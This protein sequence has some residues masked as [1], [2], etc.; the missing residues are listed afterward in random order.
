[1]SLDE[2]GWGW[3]GVQLVTILVYI[4]MFAPILV[5]V[6]LSF[7]ASQFERIPHDGLKPALV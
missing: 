3:R 5:V 2:T 1:M 6:I 7:N 4:F